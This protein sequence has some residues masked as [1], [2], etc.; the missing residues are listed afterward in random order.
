MPAELRAGLSDALLAL[1]EQANAT[2]F[3]VKDASSRYVA[4]NRTFVHRAG[5]RSA[6]EVL[7]H[8]ASELFVPELAQRYEEQDAQVLA[9]GEPLFNELELIRIPGGPYRWHLTAKLPIRH[10]GRVVGLVSMSEYVDAAGHDDP[11]LTSLAR[12][13]ELIAARLAEP[14]RVRDLAQA[15][16]CSTDTV[17]RRIER[18]FHRTPRQLI[19]SMR[20]DRARSL[21]ESTTLPVAQVAVDCG[22]YDQA[23]LTRTFARLT[24]RTPG[25]Y[26]RDRRR[27][28]APE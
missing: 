11:N 22:F 4:V 2:M 14:L 23:A 3:C 8:S 5:R 20:I 19:L 7:G 28:A 12:V 24:G 1:I 9:T 10:Q 17:T 16:G 18:V 6:A 25:Q 21:L 13:V 27:A 26:R 15:A